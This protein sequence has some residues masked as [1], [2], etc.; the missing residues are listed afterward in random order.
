MRLTGVIA[1]VAVVLVWQLVESAGLLNYEYLPA[2][3]EVLAAAAKLI[4]TGE[5]VNA[6]SHTLRITL[7]AATLSMVLGAAL[8]LAIGLLPKLRI[9]LVASIDFLRAIP[10]AALVPV[11][12]MAFGPSATTELMLVVYAALWPV[13]LCTA[14]GAASVHPR[15]YDVAQMLH[16]SRS[17]TIHKIVIP[18]AV[19]AWLI[20]ARLCA[21]IALLVS[22]V[23][24]ML[25]NLLCGV[26][27]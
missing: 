26:R 18:A 27:L 22:I 3:L 5:L 8:G 2:P 10:A 7:T 21:V 15:Q 1:P 17:A 19:P 14:A 25:M 12:V 16:L 24:E 20:G 6:V 23:A 9:Y 4:Q 13:V 11:T